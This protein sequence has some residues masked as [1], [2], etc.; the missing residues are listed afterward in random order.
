MS[1][2]V[3]KYVVAWIFN[4][5][6]DGK[7]MADLCQ[8]VFVL[9]TNETLSLTHAH[10]HEHAHTHTPPNAIGETA[11]PFISLKNTV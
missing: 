9:S 10:A 4:G 7:K 11:S 8:T 1:Y 2:N 6:Q 3:T 5:L